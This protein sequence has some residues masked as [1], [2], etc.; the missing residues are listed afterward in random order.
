LYYLN[1]QQADSLVELIDKTFKYTECDVEC[2]RYMNIESECEVSITYRNNNNYNIH[3][4]LNFFLKEIHPN[5]TVLEYNELLSIL[6]KNKSAFDNG[7][8]YAPPEKK[9][10]WTLLISKLIE[11]LD[12]ITEKSTGE[13]FILAF[14]KN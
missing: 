7:D 3:T 2:S 11:K 10:C 14:C 13:D 6:D 12:E 1:K 4:I 8:Y 5:I 9:K